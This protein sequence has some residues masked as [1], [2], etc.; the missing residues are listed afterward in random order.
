M[1]RHEQGHL[2]YPDNEGDQADEP[3]VLA[4]ILSDAVER[5]KPGSGA[6]RIRKQTTQIENEYRAGRRA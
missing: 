1:I 5:K 2:D 4:V 3:D 6:T